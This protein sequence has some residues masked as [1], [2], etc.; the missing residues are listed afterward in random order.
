MMSFSF[1]K[2]SL[3]E[4]RKNLTYLSQEIMFLLSV[5]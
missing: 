1:Q 2:A 3:K 4:I 5:T